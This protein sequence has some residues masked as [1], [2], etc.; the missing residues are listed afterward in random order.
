MKKT[1]KALFFLLLS[2]MV[3]YSC[4]AQIGNPNFASV[5]FNVAGSNPHCWA[6]WPY[7]QGVPYNGTVT[8]GDASAGPYTFYL[9]L[10]RSTTNA[11]N[12]SAWGSTFSLT[13]NY[14][15]VNYSNFSNGAP[16][17]NMTVSNRVRMKVV[18]YGG[19]GNYLGTTYSTS[20]V[21]DYFSAPAAFDFTIGGLTT[22]PTI[23]IVRYC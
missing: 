20:Q 16:M 21:F 8:V 13:S 2:T 4:I 9:T 3:S 17:L 11:A 19:K 15:N 7:P 1:V 23:P 10:E 5:T 18:V 12:W 22:N 14:N 6:Q